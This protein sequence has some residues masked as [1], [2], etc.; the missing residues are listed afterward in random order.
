MTERK[1]MRILVWVSSITGNTEQVAGAIIEELLRM[2]YTPCI[3]AGNSGL[4][5]RM[6]DRYSVIE[7]PDN[8][9]EDDADMMVI[10]CFWCRKAGMDDQ[11]I[12]FLKNLKA[13]RILVFGTMGSYPDSDYGAQVYRSVDSLV[14]KDNLLLGTFLCRGRIDEKRTEKRRNL[15]FFHPHYLNDEGYA[16]H[17]SSRSHPDG[18]DLKGAADFLRM[19]L[20]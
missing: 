13:R 4:V 12:S 10:L 8:C 11:T 20:F 15:P 19:H 16:R 2:G 17:I 7:A 18:K 3:K 5:Q 6:T 9:L 1:T 14:S